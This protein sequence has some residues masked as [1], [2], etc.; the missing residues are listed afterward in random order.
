MTAAQAA[1]A[2]EGFEEARVDAA[3]HASDLVSEEEEAL[4]LAEQARRRSAAK[5]NRRRQNKQVLTQCLLNVVNPSCRQAATAS[6]AHQLVC[7]LL[8]SAPNSCIADVAVL[9]R[10]SKLLPARKP[11]AW[12]SVDG[13]DPVLGSK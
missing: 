4:M 11:A 7:A 5:R 10:C 8:C 13:A 3:M 12:R 6:L 2:D 1:F 9:R